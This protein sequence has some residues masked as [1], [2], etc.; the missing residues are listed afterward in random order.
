MINEDQLNFIRKNLVKYL[1]EDYLPFPV[2]RSVCYEWANGLNIR[3]GGETIIYTGCSYQL[4]ELG[5]RFDEILPALSKFKGVERFSSI[6]KVFYK[7]KDTRSYK[8]LRNIA[9]VLKSSVDFGYLYE[10]EPYSGTIL[11]EMGMVEE[12]KE[13][14]KKLVEVFDSHGVKRIITVDP[15]THYTLFRIKEMLSPS[16]NV[17]IVNYFELIK[18]VKVK[19][20]G[21][22]VFHDSCL[23]SRFLGMRDSIREVIKS[24][25][26][27][28]K[29]DEMITG[30]ETSMCCGGP[31]A[32]INK[33]TSDKIARNRAEAL[34]SVHNKVLLAC[35]F[36]YANL[37]PYVEAY[38]FAEVISGE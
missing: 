19:G 32:P 7:P 35:P 30:K 33:E 3:R 29:E 23:Y 6:L 27:V 11:L 24:S 20:E 13:Y 34:K 31:L 22:F 12:F 8:I 10:D 37:S 5:K 18:N 38:D 16:W 2:N 4:A 25:G 28:L 15:H 21:T 14:A 36:C 17:E 1:M 26:I 9:S